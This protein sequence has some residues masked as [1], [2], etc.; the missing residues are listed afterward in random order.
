MWG[1]FPEGV[2]TYADRIDGIFMLILWITGAIFVLVE[3]TLVVFAFRYRHREGRRAEHVHG[4]WK[5]EA[6]WTAIPFVIVMFLAAISMEPWRDIRDPGRIPAGAYMIEVTAKQFEWN[7]LYAGADGRLGTEDDFQKRNQLF[8]PANRPVVVQLKSEDVIHSFFL[9]SMRVKQDAVPGM[10]TPV[11]FEA[12]SPGEYA[13]GCA[14]LCGLGHYRM[15]GTVT[16]LS[17]REFDAWE[18]TENDA[19]ALALSGR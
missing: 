10:E 16:V 6:V 11:W 5:V 13:L 7:A 18:R 2:S 8:V 19:I 17:A 9:P 4:N 15:R 14:E 3:V 1:W 12:T